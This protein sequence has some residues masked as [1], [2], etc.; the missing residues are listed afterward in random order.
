MPST[1]LGTGNDVVCKAEPAS[2]GL[3]GETEKADAPFLYNFTG[4]PL[5]DNK[6]HILKV[7]SLTSVH[8]HKSITIIKMMNL[9]TAPKSDLCLSVI[10]PF[11]SPNL[12]CTLMKIHKCYHQ[13]SV[14]CRCRESAGEPLT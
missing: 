8:T 13:G 9:S 7:Y 12:I 5:K 11:L 2:G 4:V 10:H 6:L 14:E 3:M 1:V